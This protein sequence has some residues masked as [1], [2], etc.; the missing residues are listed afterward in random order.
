MMRLISPLKTPLV[1]I[2]FEPHR[3][4]CS[5]ITHHISLPHFYLHAYEEWYLQHLE[6]NNLRINNY[7]LLKKQISTFF[8]LHS[9]SYPFVSCALKGPAVYERLVMM[10]TSSPSIADFDVPITGAHCH[11]RYLYPADNGHW[12]FYLT[13]I[14]FPTLFA[15]QLLANLLP[16]NLLTLTTHHMALL[17]LYKYQQ[18]TAFRNTQLA[19]D[20]RENNMK[21]ENIFDADALSRLLSMPLSLKEKTIH[22]TTPLLTACGLFVTEHAR[23]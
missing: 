19:I 8:T 20:L 5:I 6:L 17:D 16:Y 3:I 21:I 14:A 9:L 11:Y 10:A 12:V 1:T 15:F 13:A 7:T 22:A 23:I 18:S 4:S 2:I